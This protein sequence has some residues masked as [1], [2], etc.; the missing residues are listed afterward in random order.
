MGILSGLLGDGAG[1]LIK[2][3]ADAA[4]R[5]I[6]TPDERAAHE[7]KVQAIAIK[8]YLEQIEVNAKEAEHASVFVAGW[9]PGI[10]W[11]CGAALGYHFVVQPLLVFVVKVWVPDMEPPPPL[12]LGELMPILLGLLGLGGMR[13][14]ERLSGKERNAL[15][16]P[17]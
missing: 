2:G 1:G 9:R 5:F 11:I 3:V 10:G 17:K 6:E 4:D 8:P 15:R 7:L 12:S 13:T 16:R 14:A